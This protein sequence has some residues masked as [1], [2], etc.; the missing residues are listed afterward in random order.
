MFNRA[1]GAG[2]LYWSGTKDNEDNYFDGARTYKITVPLPVHVKLF[3]SITIQV[4]FSRS[5]IATGQTWQR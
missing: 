3:W 5:E 2:S 1:P 4:V